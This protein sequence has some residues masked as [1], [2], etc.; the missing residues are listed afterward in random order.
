RSS[1]SK[2]AGTALRL[3]QPTGWHGGFDDDR[4]L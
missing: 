3:F 2:L 4:R 1:G